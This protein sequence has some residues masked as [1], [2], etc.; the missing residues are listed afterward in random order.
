MN[1]TLNETLEI[2]F[3]AINYRNAIG[4]RRMGNGGH[5]KDSPFNVEIVI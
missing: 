4:N 2:T 3:N 1:R 5:K